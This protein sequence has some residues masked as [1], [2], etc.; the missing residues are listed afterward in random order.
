M[1]TPIHKSKNLQCKHWYILKTKSNFEKKVNESLQQQGFTTYL[2]T[3][4]TLRIWSDRKKKIESSL[5][6]SYVFVNC[7]ANELIAAAKTTG[8]AW[9]MHEQKKYAIV[10][11]YEIQNLRIFL[12]EKVE[13]NDDNLD[14]YEVG[15]TIKVTNGPFSGLIGTALNYQS[16]YRVR[17][18]ISSLGAD[19]TIS[20][21]K[22]Q[23]EKIIT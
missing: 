5:L 18:E 14:N 19:F 13:I 11:D 23:L 7:D 12:S 21:P 3:Y 2:P 10:K 8:V 22:S 17:I 9:I 20:V 15:E 6:P 1:Q 16:D 4:I